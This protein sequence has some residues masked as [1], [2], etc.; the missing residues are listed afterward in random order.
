MPRVSVI[1]PAFNAGPFI[2]ETVESVLA[3]Q[4][5]E[6][7]LLIADDCSS[8]DTRERL[9]PYAAHAQVR[10]LF[11][12]RNRGSAATRN[13]LIREARGVYVTPCDADDLMLPGSLRLQAEFLD[14]HPDVG[15][16]Y[17]DTLV[18]WLDDCGRIS[19]PPQIIGSDC[20]RGWDL[21]DNL[22][23]HGGSMSRRGLVEQVGGYDESVGSVDDWS[24]W[25]KMA[26]VTRIHYLEGEL[27]YVWRRH[28]ASLTCVDPNRARDIE[29]IV[30]EAAARRAG[31]SH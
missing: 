3:Q 11:H 12:E 15:V 7:E 14:L 24:L 13:T 25:L 27:T 31:R 16:V 17:G 6:L 18:I 30:R 5:V 1:M 9:Q 23:N 10:L 19:R 26:E 22:V 8:D 28:A 4:G 21:R 2:K 20:N 29:K